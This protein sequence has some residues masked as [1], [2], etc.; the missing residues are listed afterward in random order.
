MAFHSCV[1]DSGLL[2]SFERLCGSVQQ[3]ET[4]SLIKQSCFE[5]KHCPLKRGPMNRL[6]AKRRL[7]QEAIVAA[8][9]FLCRF[10]QAFPVTLCDKHCLH[11]QHSSNLISSRIIHLYMKME[12]SAT[13]YTV[14]MSLRFADAILSLVFC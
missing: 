6:K 7:K 8:F 3:P 12:F 4:I 1:C 2:K 14:C 13:F 11:S 5:R 10:V 9:D